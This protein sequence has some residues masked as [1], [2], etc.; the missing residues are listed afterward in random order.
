MV[1]DD[2]IVRGTT[3]RQSIEDFKPAAAETDCCG[4]FSSLK[5]VSGL[6]WH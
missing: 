6:L 1:I 5:E 2:S 3:L 4:V